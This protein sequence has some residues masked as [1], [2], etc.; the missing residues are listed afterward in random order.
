MKSLSLFQVAQS[1]LQLSRCCGL[2][3]LWEGIVD[4]FHK[5]D[6]LRSS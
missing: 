4:S 1:P 3:K 2:E 5:I 6:I